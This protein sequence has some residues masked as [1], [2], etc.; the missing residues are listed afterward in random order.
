M[1]AA[2]ATTLA[3]VC[4]PVRAALAVLV[5]HVCTSPPWVRH[6]VAGFQ[7]YVVVGFVGQT[8]RNAEY[9]GFGGR[10]WWRLYR[11][12]HI[13]TYLSSLVL[14]Y[15]VARCYAWVPLAADVAFAAVV[16]ARHYST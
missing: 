1:A 15:T 6:V 9:G 2:R 5:A 4:L 13:F 8:V 12:V 16:G 14:L 7:G 11:Y 10:V 3:L